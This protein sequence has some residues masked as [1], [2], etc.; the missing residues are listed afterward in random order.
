MDE[1]VAGVRT[2]HPQ[3]T[4]GDVKRLVGDVK[5]Y[6]GH[7]VKH[8]G[9]VKAAVLGTSGDVRPIPLPDPAQMVS[10]RSPGLTPELRSVA[11]EA[12]MGFFSAPTDLRMRYLDRYFESHAEL[13]LQ[14]IAEAEDVSPLGTDLEAYLLLLDTNVVLG[15]LGHHD[16]AAVATIRTMAT[17]S[18]T[19]GMAVA[20]SVHTVQ[21]FMAL[22]DDADA[23]YRSVQ[24][25]DR[26]SREAAAAAISRELDNVLINSFLR[27]CARGEHE[28]WSKFC[29]RHRQLAKLLKSYGVLVVDIP[30]P[31]VGRSRLDALDSLVGRFAPGKP[32]VVRRHDTVHYL[33][34]RKWRLEE[35]P[36]PWSCWFISLDSSLPFFDY[37]ARK[38]EVDPGVAFCMSPECWLTWLRKTTPARLTS[39]DMSGIGALAFS[40]PFHR[41]RPNAAVMVR[42]IAAVKDWQGQEPADLILA[43]AAEEWLHEEARK[44]Y[45]K[46]G[47]YGSVVA[48][49]DAK[50]TE[51]VTKV[52]RERSAAFEEQLSILRKQA[53]ELSEQRAA[54]D[55][56]RQRD[57]E[58]LRTRV[59]EAEQ[60]ADLAETRRKHALQETEKAAWRS[61][62]LVTGF[63]GLAASLGLLLVLVW[64]RWDSVFV[65]L[66]L[67]PFLI[68]ATY[69]LWRVSRAWLMLVTLLLIAAGVLPAGHRV[70]HS[71]G[72][73]PET[74]MLWHAR[75]TTL[76]TWGLFIFEALVAVVG[77]KAAV[78][79]RRGR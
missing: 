54:E 45:A 13:C 20:V 19:L 49:M 16:E 41:P 66:F 12:L 35:V 50:L 78:G 30:V 64:R 62:V 59:A 33:L 60:K 58:E 73:K 47:P 21:E 67:S 40:L 26:V 17:T 9:S 23:L 37:E 51:A 18:R 46:R 14:Y 39:A 22:L 3:L 38:Q 68:C 44:A 55:Q 24:G 28:T 53:Q 71:L 34:V 32:S 43:V 52:S 72:L 77:G 25:P 61:R 31:D 7:W 11:V 6:M 75:L 79:R 27:S 74:E 63:S 76:G 1:W 10:E 42:L 65:P 2:K 4:D 56:K 57:E 69:S 8:Y 36:N 15:L 5:A 48:D 29:A 70:F